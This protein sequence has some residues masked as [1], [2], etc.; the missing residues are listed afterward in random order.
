[1]TVF[2]KMIDRE[3]WQRLAPSFL[4]YNYRQLWD[5]GVACAGRLGATNEHIALHDG[6]ELIGLADVRIKR[7]PL[8]ESGIAYINGG[9]LVRC[10]ADDTSA[11]GKLRVVLTELINI[12][13]V[14]K[15]LVLRIQPPL[16]PNGWNDQIKS[17]FREL[18]FDTNVHLHSYRTIV[19]DLR[20]SIEDI[21]K[22][23]QQKWRNCLNGTEKRELTIK[24]GT[25]ENSFLAFIDLYMALKLRKEFD[26]NLYPQFYLQAHRN[27]TERERFLVTL[28]YEEGQPVA[29]HV[30]SILGDTCVYL[31]GATNDAGLKSKAAYLA[32]WSVIQMARREGCRFY[33]LGGIDPKNNPGVH[34]FKKG[35]GGTDIT[36]PGPFELNPGGLK[37]S[38]L[39]ECEHLY[40][41]LQCV[42]K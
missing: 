33:D 20:P 10:R 9:P 2:L 25:D 13:V 3:C 22:Q 41:C 35:L 29:G 19:V 27:L 39:K 28:I 15:K 40:R 30:G 38:L 17:V 18:G 11:I 7:L 23:F 5:F 31:L 36:V 6:T 16:G 24:T 32:Q 37:Y 34:H 42:L 14:Q 1:M 4:D 12:Y 26:V 21:R 8:F